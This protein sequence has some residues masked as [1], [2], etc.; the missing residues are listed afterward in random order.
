MERI[1]VSTPRW[2]AP[3]TT[4]HRQEGDG[5]IL[6][7]AKGQYRVPYALLAGCGP[8]RAREALRLEIGKHSSEDSRTSYIRRMARR[9]ELQLNTK[10]LGER[11]G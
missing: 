10:T 4:E 8:M 2:L 1:S 5:S 11:E 3:E 9:G 7:E 6:K